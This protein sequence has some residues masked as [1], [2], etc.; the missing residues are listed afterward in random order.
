M[1]PGSIVT[2]VRIAVT[3][4]CLVWGSTW[5]VVREGLSEMQPFGSGGMRFFLAWLVMSAVAPGIAAR[6]GGERPTWRLVVVMATGN[7]AISS[8]SASM[9]RVELKGRHLLKDREPP[10]GVCPAK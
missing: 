2:P 1:N 7:F 10:A 6:E 3:V 9:S 5:F 8:I 4:M